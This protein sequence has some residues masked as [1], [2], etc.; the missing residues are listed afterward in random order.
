M[1]SDGGGERTIGGIHRHRAEG[2]RVAEEAGHV[3]QV[4]DEEVVDDGM[5]IVEVEFVR[6]VVGVGA[7]HYERERETKEEGAGA[8]GS[9]RG[10]L[11][12][13]GAL[14]SFGRCALLCSG[15]F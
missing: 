13:G 9:R 14:R 12:S 6:E 5:E 8:S 15:T 11:G 1:A 7:Q 10:V 3:V 4:G 2:H